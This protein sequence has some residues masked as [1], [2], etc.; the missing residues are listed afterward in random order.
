MSSIKF[1]DLGGLQEDGKNLYVLEIDERIFIL[2]AGIKYP[3]SELYGVDYIVPNI[4]YLVENKER[5]VG[6]FLTHAHTEHIGAVGNILK[7]IPVKIYASKFTIAVLKDMLNHDKISYDEKMIIEISRKTALHF[8]NITV[9]F[10][11]VAHNVFD[12]YGIDIL[13]EDGNIIYTGNYSFDQNVKVDYASMFRMLAIFAKEGVLALLTESLGAINDQNRGTILE[14][15]M[16]LNQIL[17]GA[18]GRVIFSIFSSD[19]LRMQQIIDIGIANNR[20]IAVIG[21]KTQ[22]L[23]NVAMNLGYL[24]IPNEYL[25]NLRYI[26]EKNKNLDDDLLVLVCGERHEPYYMLQRMSRGVDRLVNINSNDTVVILT[27]PY[28]GT[29]KMA[30]RTLDIIYHKTSKVKVFKKELMPASNA[31]R[32]EIK[33][34]INILKPKYIIPVIGEY[35]HQFACEVVANCVGHP[36]ENFLIA[37]CGDILEFEN[38]KYVGISGDVEVGENLVDGKAFSDVGDVVMHDRELLAEDGVF[39]IS[40]LVNPKNKTISEDI[41]IVTK[42]FIYVK[43]N[44]ELLTEVKELFKKVTSKYFVTKYVNWSDLKTNLRNEIGH[45]LYKATKRNPIVIPVL[46]ATDLIN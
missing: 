1:I 29:E 30:A 11:Q 40:A 36:D 28:I 2:D 45:Y 32:E 27:T 6:L 41:Q 46:I 12:A 33:E 4:S 5:I 19:L 23:V 39:L 3:T 18:Q 42:G 22:R 35:R 14:F 20:R 9:R 44:E 17:A 21:R 38:G 8:G 13:T 31:T 37:D 10:F 26:D 43:D 34:M 15:K 16:R 24:H 7:E 25:A